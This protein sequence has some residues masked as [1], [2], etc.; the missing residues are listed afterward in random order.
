MSDLRE[1]E[2]ARMIREQ[3]EATVVEMCEWCGEPVNNGRTHG[4]G[5]CSRHAPV[6]LMWTCVGLGGWRCLAWPR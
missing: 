6:R 2:H 1:T 4:E 3:E 5:Q